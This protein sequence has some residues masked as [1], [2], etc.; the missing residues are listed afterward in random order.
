MP[1]CLSQLTG[2]LAKSLIGSTFGTSYDSEAYFAANRFAEILFNL[3]AGGALGSAFIPTFTGLLSSKKTKDAWKLASSVSNLI[4]LVLTLVG[5][6][7]WIFARPIVHYILA[8]G[9]AAKDPAIETLTVELLRI[10]IP[11]AVIFG[12]SGLVMG[13]LNA[14]QHFILPALAPSMYQAGLIF[15]ALVLSRGM[16]IYGLA[17]GC[18]DWFGFSFAFAGAGFAAFTQS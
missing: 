2:L 15:G 10:Q 7:S 14:H 18:G 11:S 3:M 13:I 12:L 4:F 8:P 16:G 17:W 9:F 5:I 1:W 6:L